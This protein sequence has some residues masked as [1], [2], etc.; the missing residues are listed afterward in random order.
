MTRRAFTGILAYHSKTQEMKSL[1]D[2]GITPIDMVVC[3]LYPFEQVV[4]KDAA[5]PELIENIDIDGITLLQFETDV[6]HFRH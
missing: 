4:K 5:L 1:Q 2:S 3:N 6:K